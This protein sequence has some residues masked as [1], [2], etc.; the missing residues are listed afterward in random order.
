MP[1]PK[2]QDKLDLIDGTVKIPPSTDARFL[3]WQRCNDLVITWI[4]HSI[5]A[6]IARIVKFSDITSAVWADLHDRFSQG[7][8]KKLSNVV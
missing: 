2:R 3:L 6:Y 5:R 8:G 7:D 1:P 4:L